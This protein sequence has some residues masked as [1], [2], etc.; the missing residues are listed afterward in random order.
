MLCA[1]LGYDEGTLADHLIGTSE[2]ATVLR[3]KLSP[4]R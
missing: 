1:E 2:R 3:S 4:P